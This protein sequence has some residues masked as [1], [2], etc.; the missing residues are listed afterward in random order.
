MC[1]IVREGDV[2]VRSDMCSG[3]GNNYLVSVIEGVNVCLLAYLC[4]CLLE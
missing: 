2:K 4:A 3:D 1:I